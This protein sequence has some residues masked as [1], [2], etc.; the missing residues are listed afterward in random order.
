MKV[1]VVRIGNSRGIRIP[2]PILEHCGFGAQVEMTVKGAILEIAPTRAI[3][4]SWDNAF[5]AM[6]AAGDDH[7][8]FPEDMSHVWDE[9]EWEW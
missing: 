7:V 3:R 5:E 9:S 8:L 6:A 1:D 4:E 2:K